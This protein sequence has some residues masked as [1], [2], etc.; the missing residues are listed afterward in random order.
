MTLKGEPDL[1]VVGEAGA[2]PP[3]PALG[4]RST[5]SVTSEDYYSTAKMRL[6]IPHTASISVLAALTV[7]IV[8]TSSSLAAGR[9]RADAAPHGAQQLLVLDR[10]VIARA[11]PSPTSAALDAVALRTP[12]TGSQMTLPIVGTSTGPAGGRWL[13]VRLPRRPNGVTG[14]VPADSG[15]ISET[16]WRVVIHRARRSAVV[17]RGAEQRAV[18]PVV[19]GKPS[20]PTPLGTFFIVEKLHLARGVSEGPWALATSAYSDVLQEFAGGPGQIALHGIVGLT[21][22]LGTF[23]SHGCI[24]FSSTAINWLAAHVGDGTPVVILPR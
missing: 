19:L 9:E 12:L 4:H 11:G 23:A 1:R 13:R 5:L 22:P 17:L 15:T 16:A 7:G 21:A 6:R 24:R 3:R 18:F 14:W 8:A 2:L 10:K 20:T